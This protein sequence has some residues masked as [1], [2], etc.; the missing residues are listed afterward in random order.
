MFEGDDKDND[1][2][3]DDA[4]RSSGVRYVFPKG[5]KGIDVQIDNSSRLRSIGTLRN[6]E[7]SP[8]LPVHFP[9]RSDEDKYNHYKPSNSFPGPSHIYLPP[10]MIP[11]QSPSSIVPTSFIRPPPQRPTQKPT[12]RPTNRPINSYVPPLPSSTYLPPTKSTTTKRPS[13]PNNTYL[14]PSS[15]NHPSTSK[16]TTTTSR[17]TASSQG[18]NQNYL[19]TGLV[20][21]KEEEKENV[22]C[23]IQSECCGESS[24]GK[25]VIPIPLKNRNSNDCCVKTAK[26]VVPLTHFDKK[27]V[28]KL[29]EAFTKEEFDADK[30]IRSILENML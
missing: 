30:L 14:P 19:I 15:N 2:D 26:L 13:T 3:G 7:I 17:P 23:P 8:R 11:Q 1:D 27:A 22:V 16:T 5:C 25:L 4:V 24:G 21:P 18:N 28:E 6:M 10:N 29:K 12:Q 20:P 9:N